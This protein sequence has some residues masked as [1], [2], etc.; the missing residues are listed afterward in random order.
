MTSPDLQIVGAATADGV[1]EV[2]A[3]LLRRIAALEARTVEAG[4]PGPP[5][6][7]GER[8]LDGRDGRDGHDGTNG[9]DG[10]DGADGAPGPIGERGADG[11]DGTNGKDGFGLEDFSVAY[12]GDRTLSFRFM[13]GE[14]ERCQIVTLPMV[15]YRGVFAEGQTYAVGDAVTAGG[16]VWIAKQATSAKPGL[17]SEESRAWQLAVK[18][19]RDG[20]MGP[21][22]PLGPAGPRGESG[23]PRPLP[24]LSVLPIP[25]SRL[26]F[27]F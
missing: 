15:I 14:L 17:P 12:D 20:P 24:P 27:P 2:C 8:G 19:G 5:G 3:P 1:R 25:P 11:H 13:R 6:L 10:R 9:K 4:P 23:A 21:A 18:K 16:S 22:G 26:P 7:A